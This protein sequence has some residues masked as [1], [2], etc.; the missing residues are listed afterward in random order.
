MQKRWPDRLWIVRHGESAGNV[1]RDAA[2]AAG[3]AEIDIAERDVD[4]PLS[5]L[6]ERA[7]AR[8]GALVRRACRPDERP[9]VVLVSPYRRAQQTARADPRR[10]AA[11]T[12]TRPSSSS[13]SACARR[14]SASSTG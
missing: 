3:C 12:R 2:H 9:N 13:T 1:A 8:A 14:S 7:V 10:P 6:G 4:V 11:S 5:P